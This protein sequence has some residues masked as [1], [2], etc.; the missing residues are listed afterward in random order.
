MASVPSIASSMQE[1]TDAER[2]AGEWHPLY[3]MRLPL[4]L[5]FWVWREGWDTPIRWSKMHPQSN[6]VGLLWKQE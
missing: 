4:L 6:I 2:P 5:D 1:P 3:P